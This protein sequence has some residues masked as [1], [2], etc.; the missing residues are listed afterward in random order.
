M[1]QS[2]NKSIFEKIEHLAG[3][4]NVL[5]DEP[6]K[7]HTSFRIG[8][9]ADCFV[10]V[11]DPGVFSEMIAC[12][13][14]NDIPYFIMGNG[15]N[16]LVSDR[17]F[18]G[19]VFQLQKSFQEVSFEGNTVKA[20]AGVLLSAL[21]HKALEQELTGLEF[22]S[23]IPGTLGGAVVMNAGAYG[24]EIKNVLVKAEV[25]KP[26][27]GIR[28]MNVSDLQLG[29]RTSIFKHTDLIVLGAEL[30]LEQGEK[31]KIEAE[32][33]RLKIERTSKQPL[34]YPSA[35]S[36]FKRPE[37][38]FAGKLIMDTGLRGFSVGDAAV[39]EKHCG[40]IINK[41]A[42]T[43]LDVKTLISEIIRRVEETQGVTLVPEI[44]FLGEF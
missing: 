4:E 37:G 35:G 22:A 15:T 2:M 8:G 30:V 40:F 38:Y 17:G 7:K 13:M 6:M 1:E 11:S 26:G 24:G 21:S 34:E 3:P 32:M 20:S 43:A 33:E 23:G 41:G 27:E 9:P 25:L 19:V 44:R 31:E 18:R 5:F 10:T 28:V 16:L 42:A 12:C 29:Y 36:A 39:S 14:E